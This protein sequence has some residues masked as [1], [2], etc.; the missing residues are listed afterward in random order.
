MTIRHAATIA[1]NGGIIQTHNIG[2]TVC[3]KLLYWGT[4]SERSAANPQLLQDLLR[5][6]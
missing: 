5:I 6:G 2:G 3:V 1:I 4:G